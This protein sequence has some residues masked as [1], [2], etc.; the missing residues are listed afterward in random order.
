MTDEG[1]GPPVPEWARR[2]A[3]DEAAPP[4]QSAP[5]PGWYPDPSGG[6]YG[7]WWDGQQ[8]ADA[9]QPLPQQAP[10]PP[11][12]PPT[13]YQYQH[14]GPAYGATSQ[15]QSASNGFT[16]AGIVLGA[17]ALIVFPIIFGP[18]AIVMAAIALVRQ[19]RS[20]AVA[21]GIAVGGTVLGFFFGFL[22]FL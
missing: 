5:P 14:A 16:V 7:R 19:E 21:M 13:G 11:A 4:P 20:A 3:A 2:A 22:A 17:I 10:P 6:P 12:V 1:H 18:L 15:S 8:W 9:T